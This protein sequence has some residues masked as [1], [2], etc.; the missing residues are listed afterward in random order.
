MLRGGD[1]QINEKEKEEKFNF[2][3]TCHIFKGLAIITFSCIHQSDFGDLLTQSNTY[4]F[5]LS[6]LSGV[7]SQS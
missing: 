7:K 5:S 4:A 6:T 2:F 3:P 1:K